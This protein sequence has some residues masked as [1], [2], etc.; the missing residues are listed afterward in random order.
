MKI[1]AS[2]KKAISIFQNIVD[3]ESIKIYE[4]LFIQILGYLDREVRN[5]ELKILII[6]IS[7]NMARK[8]PLLLEITKKQLL[9]EELNCEF[10]IDKEIYGKKVLY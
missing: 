3:F 7:N 10:T 1:N 4:K 5:D 8:N 2:L 9:G 6:F